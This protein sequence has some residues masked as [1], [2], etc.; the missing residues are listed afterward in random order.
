MPK[1]TPLPRAM[2][3][4]LGLA[5][6]IV[7]VSVVIGLSGLGV[8]ALTGS[9]GSRVSASGGGQGSNPPDALPEIHTPFTVSGLPGDPRLE[10]IP[11]Q[12]INLV[13]VDV[14]AAGKKVKMRFPPRVNGQNESDGDKS[15]DMLVL[16]KD[17]SPVAQPP[18]L[19]AVPKNG[20]GPNVHI[21]DFTARMFSPIW[22]LHAVTVVSSYDP[23]DPAMLI[24]SFQKVN[25]SP[26]VKEILATN[27]FLN[28]PV[29]PVGTTVDPEF[30]TPPM[31]AFY[32]G[33]I[34]S[35]VPYDIEDGGFNVQVMFM[36]TEEKTLAEGGK[37]L[38]ELPYHL[39]ASFPP[40]EP[41]YTS[42]WEIW[43][44]VV[45]KDF[46]V[47]TLKSAADVKASGFPIMSTGLRL[48]CPVVAI[49]T[50]PNTG[51]FTPF[52]FENA[53]G[54]LLN[55]NR[56]AGFDIL[57]SEFLPSRSFFIT[58]INPVLGG[59]GSLSKY[60]LIDPDVLGKGN[61]IPLIL[62]NPFSLVDPVFP[63]VSGPNT[64]GERIRFTQQQLDDGLKKIP[65][66]LPEAIEANFAGFIAKGLL[67]EEWAPGGGRSYQERLA[68]VGWALH[69][70]VWTP[71]QGAN[72]KDTTTCL[73]CHS[74]PAAGGAARGL[75]SLERSS[76][77]DLITKLNPGSMW[78]SGGAELLIQQKVANGLVI[79]P[80][81]GRVAGDH[82][83]AHGSTG[84]IASIR[85]V[86]AG[87]RNAHFG[88]QTTH[89]ISSR[90][91]CDLDGDG[92]TTIAEAAMPSCDPDGDGR[93]NESTV[94]E[95][96]AE[97]VFLLSLPVPD[98]ASGEMLKVLGVTSASVQQG[99][100]LFTDAGCASCHTPFHPLK[101]VFD[102]DGKLLI[103]IDTLMLSN[104]ETNSLLPIT[105]S[106]HVA[107]Q[108]DVDD[109]L[110]DSVGQPGLR[111]FGDFRLHE[112]GAL[113]KSAG[114]AGTSLIKSAEL[115]DVGSTYPYLRD[116]SK[117]SDLRAVIQA[118]GGAG[119]EAV[120]SIK[121]FKDLDG[122]SQQHIINFLRAQLIGDKVGE[123]SSGK[124]GQGGSAEDGSSVTQTAIE[125]ARCSSDGR[126]EVRGTSNV[127]GGM[128]TVLD[129]A[130]PNEEFGSTDIGS[131]GKW[132]FEKDGVTC[133]EK[134]RAVN[135][136]GG[137]PATADV[138][139]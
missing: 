126:L 44:V 89:R 55:V 47:T 118:H 41:F 115:W 42:L 78:G 139:K 3:E 66:R 91:E 53:F 131:D 112:M 76:G 125:R 111:N 61:V 105:V 20:A 8:S 31:D 38:E 34:V 129:D 72:Q 73:A 28:A 88:I 48:N 4:L 50:G 122:V 71:E 85:D 52:P 10:P 39:V 32:N 2:H 138:S 11:D 123:G 119:S 124:V 90:N 12:S 95:V 18:I 45:P 25:S 36:F 68:L 104:L 93:F 101:D 137:A 83:N 6:V 69:A 54:M 16:F 75:Y 113:M 7:V 121:A 13:N 82:T 96:T 17:G 134:V 117:G 128:I 19:E 92:V 27:M 43:N 107:N 46:D 132:R 84:G 116:G 74:T 40:G 14:F 59:A 63:R 21:S 33:H 30:T 70:L 106:H 127:D 80:R 120:D 9:G 133:P 64:G 22:K 56:D 58:E 102:A 49:E 114:T 51:V 94:G 24:D 87:A 23:N 65:P 86:V 100:Q 26:L 15:A 57:E 79:K 67:K 37:V 103:K 1:V 62:K 109:G 108:E 110:A 136:N 97:A 98:Q 35:I 5:M 130:P 135:S 29:V 60:P 77:S 81:S 99:R